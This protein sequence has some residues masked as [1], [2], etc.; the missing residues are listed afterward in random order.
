[1]LKYTIGRV[2]CSSS[3]VNLSLVLR[4]SLF[5]YRGRIVAEHWNPLTELSD[6]VYREHLNAMEYCFAF[7]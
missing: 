7:K 3:L 5:C 6:D 4:L 2:I 1:M